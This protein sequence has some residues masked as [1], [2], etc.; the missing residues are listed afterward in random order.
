MASVAQVGRHIQEAK[1][2][3]ER[4]EKWQRALG[5]CFWEI[6]C[7]EG[8][9]VKFLMLSLSCEAKDKTSSLCWEQKS[10]PTPAVLLSRALSQCLLLWDLPGLVL[11]PWCRE[12]CEVLWIRISQRVPL[13]N[14]LPLY[15]ALEQIYDFLLSK[16]LCIFL[17]YSHPLLIFVFC[18]FSY[19]CLTDKLLQWCPSQA[20]HTLDIFHYPAVPFKLCLTVNS[21]LLMQ[22][23]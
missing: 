20:P 19:W 18:V 12:I 8:A 6:V 13:D 7:Q 4:D 2:S 11:C 22:I 17:N 15:H 23:K 3:I 14:S 1:E 10:M 16:R 21:C 5:Y 9:V